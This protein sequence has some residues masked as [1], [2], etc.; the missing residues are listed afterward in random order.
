MSNASVASEPRHQARKPRGFGES[1][2]RG[3]YDGATTRE[4]MDCETN[5]RRYGSSC[6]CGTHEPLSRPFDLT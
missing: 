3:R 6:M 5:I 2:A 4:Q 1:P